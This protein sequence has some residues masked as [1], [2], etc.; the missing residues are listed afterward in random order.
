MDLILAMLMHV[1]EIQV[2]V[3]STW[4]EKPFREYIDDLQG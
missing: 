3:R 1:Q 4:Q 2:K